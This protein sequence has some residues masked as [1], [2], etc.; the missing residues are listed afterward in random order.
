MF[1]FY[2][3]LGS[4]AITTGTFL[5]KSP[6]TGGLAYSTQQV[7]WIY[8]TFALGGMMATPLV[9]VLVD[10]LFRAEI[11][12]GV[13][14]IACG[15][16]LFAAGNW[17][18]ASQPLALEA[19]RAS[20]GNFDDPQVRAAADASFRTLF[21]IMLA[22]AFCL[23]ISLTLC[24]VL[25]LRNLPDPSHQFSRTRMFGT[26]GWVLVCNT[27]GFF[28]LPTSPMPFH[29]G[30]VIAV[31]AG[32]YGFS[33]PATPPKGTGKG[34]GEAFGLPAFKLFRDRSFCT[35]IAVSLINSQM[36]QFYGVYGHRFLTDRGVPMPE[37]WMTLGQIMEVACMFA[38]PLLNPK[39]NMKWLMLL[40]TLGGAVRAMA[41]LLGSDWLTLGLGVPMHGWSF[42]FYYVVAASFIDREAPPHLR[43]SAQSI[44][45]F[46]ASGLGPWTGNMIAAN[47]LDHYQDGNRIDWASVWVVPLIGSLLATVLFAVGFRTT[48]THVH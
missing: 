2:A 19:F 41:M 17:C 20:S 14:S 4:W 32:I 47:V 28:M 48:K 5:L 6:D 30:G 23:Q 44:A 45:A 43:A 1:L 15:V 27:L 21:A 40:G 38:I 8:S 35:F 36:N 46:V 16:L 9:G 25:S 13:F 24:T 37:R 3:S 7:G 26:V 34:L 10:R 31:V 29:L 42:A 11:V 33:L 18:E 12:F 39:K 22:Q